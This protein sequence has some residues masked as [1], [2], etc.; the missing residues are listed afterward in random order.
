VETRRLLATLELLNEFLPAKPVK[1]IASALKEHLDE[2]DDLRDT[3][4]GLKLAKPLR[5]RFAVACE[6]HKHLLDR[7]ERF[8]RRA[9]KRIKKVKLGQVREWVR[10]CRQRLEERTAASP[11]E[12][13][14]TLLLHAVTRTFARVG[15]YRAAVDARDT[16]TIHRTRVAFKHFR[17]MVEALADCLPIATK[18]RLDAMRDYQTLMGDVQDAQVL[19]SA[20]DKFLRKRDAE[21]RTAVR[22]RKELLWQRNQLIKRY[23]AG[24]DSLDKFWPA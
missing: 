10:D 4:V 17:Y 6:F 11:R 15:R 21:P 12:R 18:R 20:V 2:F 14:N 13:A 16:R 5:D 1:Q 22:F 8:T 24:A 9:H 19:L 23:L 7:E 3:Q